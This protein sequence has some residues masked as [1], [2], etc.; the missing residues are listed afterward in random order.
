VVK[1]LCDT[2]DMVTTNGSM[3]FDGFRPA[4]DAFQVAR[5]R[6]HGAVIIGKAALEEYATY[7]SNSN[8]VGTGVERVQ[9]VEVGEQDVIGLQAGGDRGAVEIANQSRGACAPRHR[10]LALRNSSSLFRTDKAHSPLQKD[11]G[12][13][14]SGYPRL[15]GPATNLYGKN[16]THD[17]FL[18]A[19]GTQSSFQALLP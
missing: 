9:P 5:L 14:A 4:H 17:A 2:F 16:L 11:Q 8:D 7:G 18:R 1:N 12:S 15:A 3:T 6:E 13:A 19:S 10:R